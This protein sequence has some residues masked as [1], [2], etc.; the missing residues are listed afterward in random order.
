MDR[1]YFLS[2]SALYLGALAVAGC[3]LDQNT[4]KSQIK[5]DQ[6][7]N[8][9]FILADDMGYGDIQAYNSESKIPTP[10]LNRLASQG[11]RFTD[12]H[13]GSAVCSP[14]RYGLLTGRYCW[15]TELKSGVL[16]PPE[17]K[18]L[19]GRDRL[20]VAGL[21]KQQGYHTACIGKWH[22]GMD[23]GLDENGN[24][25]FNRP[26]RY[27]PTDVGFDEFFGIAGSLDMIPYVFYRNHKPTA[28]VT[29]TQT[30]LPFPKFIREGP[31]SMDFDPEKVLD[32][33]TK[34]AVDTIDK[35]AAETRPF[36]LYLPLTAPHKPV[37]PSENFRNKTDLGP[38][39]DFIL[40]TDWSVGRVLQALEDNGI[41]GNTLVVFSSDNGSYM[42]RQPEDTEDHI[43]DPKIQGYL[44][45]NHKANA[46][47]RGTKADIWEAGHRIPFI[48][49][50]PGKVEP[51]TRCSETICLTDFMATCA[52]ITGFSLPENAAEDSFNLLP[53]FQGKD[54]PVPRAP[55]I[56]HSSNGMFS[57]REGKWKMVFGNGSGGREKPVG[58]PFEESYFLFDLENDPMERENLIGQYPE[59][60]ERM[61]EKL[62]TIMDRGRSR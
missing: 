13:S 25:D 57:L 30:G 20:T 52:K 21:L 33:L 36:F 7:P 26:L 3:K 62:K 15:R 34:Q 58:K 27:G 41:A 49:R 5:K 10:H 54:W 43:H 61:T 51:D 31:K 2:S 35:R 17:D 44:P 60:A 22:L 32:R 47:W 6:L 50:W 12:A 9:V 40:Q 8:I 38:Y 45:S 48:V 46:D 1:R 53:L 24:V 56:H 42:F 16:W 19:I 39:G 29:D 28:P 11:V 59:V 37:W 14:T 4:S 23:W 55:V 18:P